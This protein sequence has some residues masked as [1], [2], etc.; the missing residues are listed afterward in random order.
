MRT[1]PTQLTTAL[2]SGS[3]TPVFRINQY[4]ATSFVRSVDVISFEI[5]DVECKASFHTTTPQE[6]FNKFTIE[7]G[8]I[9]DNIEYTI[10]T[11]T[12]YATRGNWE[13]EIEY[14]EG[15]LFPKEYLQ[16]P[17]DITYQELIETVC[18]LYDKHPIFVNPSASY[19]NY[20][21]YPNG[22]ILKCLKVIHYSKTKV[23]NLWN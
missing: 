17:A 6:D 14:I 13:N 16:I 19:L 15:Q 1:L 21:F 7:R 22:R 8:V 3:F 20:Q 23:P 18:A 11:S 9:I 2:E 12:M 5:N 4:Y 10:S